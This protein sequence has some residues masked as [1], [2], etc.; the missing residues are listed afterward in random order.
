M[1][2]G[3]L[4]VALA[5]VLSLPPV[6]PAAAAEDCP[7]PGG[8]T[9]SR[10]RAD[11]GDF[12]FTGGG[13]GHGVGMSQYGARGAALLGCGSG[14]ILRAYFPGTRVA[15]TAPRR[16][17]VSLSTSAS[18]L[19]VRTLAGAVPWRLC[20]DGRCRTVAS[21][22]GGVEWKARVR[23]DGSYLLRDGETV[24]WRGGDA[25]RRLKASLGAGRWGERIVRLGSGARY[26]WGT[27]EL[28]SVRAVRARAYVNLALPLERYLYGLAEMPS[29]WPAAALRA[30]AVAGRTY[31]L[32]RVQT[33]RGDRPGCR[34]DVY[35][36][37][38]DQ[39][40]AGYDKEA[41]P[42][43][44]GARWVAA[45]RATD[46]R[47]LRWHGETAQ[48]FYASSHGGWSE[49]SR[50]V[51]GGDVPYLRAVDDRRWEA[52]SGN[53]RTS[54]SRAYDA[55]TLGSLLGVGTVRR[56]RLPAPRG[57]GGRVGDPSR[58]YGGV[59]VVGTTGRRTFSGDAVRRRLGLH[60]T[61]FRAGPVASR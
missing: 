48:A 12:H 24:R 43:G 46:G 22:P 60:S 2:R 28:D 7:P 36:T 26:R 50:F 59:R 1:R 39:V 19:A 49:S 34:C 54:W 51:W 23:A 18:S 32:R 42:G 9:L 55:R 27:L 13:W 16:I 35:A 4:V 29:S 21:Q 14:Q 6:P 52:A 41:E 33:H 31:A 37:T 53:P 25:G 40:Y 56:V 38:V 45:V 17:R 15:D 10:P 30:Q 5:V 44:H 58:G 61:L 57:A 8:V 47:A 20:A 11:D 3:G